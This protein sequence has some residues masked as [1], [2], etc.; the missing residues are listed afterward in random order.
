MRQSRAEK[1]GVYEAVMWIGGEVDGGRKMV[2]L[3]LWLGDGAQGGT[4]GGS[5]G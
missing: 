5:G 3:G 2:G 4:V 1:V